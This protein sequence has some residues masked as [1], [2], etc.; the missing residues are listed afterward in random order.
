MSKTNRLMFSVSQMHKNLVLT[1]IKSC[2][3]IFRSCACVCACVRFH[4]H[5][6]L[7]I[8]LMLALV[9]ASLVKTRLYRQW[10]KKKKKDSEKGNNEM[11]IWS[12]QLWT[13]LKQL[14]FLSQ[15]KI[16]AS[17]GLEPMTSSLLVRCS[18]NWAMKPH[19]TMIIYSFHSISAVHIYMISFIYS[20]SQRKR[21]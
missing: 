11:N 15:K 21:C 13:Q 18:T 6:I 20:S 16:L 17:T 10:A 12:S 2:R 3:W 1:M 4:F 19:V 9:L 14:Q 8:A 5:I 7:V